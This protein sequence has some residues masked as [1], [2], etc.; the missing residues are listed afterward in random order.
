MAD[1]II[2]RPKASLSSYNHNSFH[3]RN[4]WV[5]GLWSLLYPGFGHISTGSM[6]KGFLLFAGELLVNYKANLN[7]AILYSFTGSFEEAKQVLNTQWLLIYSS[8]LLFAMWDSYRLTVEFNKL[9]VLADREKAPL[10]PIGIDSIGINFFDK[11]NPWVSASWSLMLPGLGQMYN[12]NTV[13]AAFVA[14]FACGIIIASHGLQAILYTFLGHF[15]QAR[16]ILDW[17]WFINL[18]AFYGFAAWDAYLSTIEVNK[19]FAIEQAQYFKD[20]YLGQS[21]LRP[22]P[23]KGG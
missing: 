17:Q 3:L 14:I 13:K 7:L 20:N 8:V 16:I 10:S 12:G 23:L 11:R 15:E 9:S 1:Q 18:P 21:L 2:R 19:L 22:F 4:P 6:A 5:I